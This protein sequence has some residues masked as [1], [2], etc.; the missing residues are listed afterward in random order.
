[1]VFNAGLSRGAAGRASETCGIVHASAS[2][3]SGRVAHGNYGRKQMDALANGRLFLALLCCNRDEVCTFAMP[4]LQ[5][6]FTK[7]NV[8]SSMIL[9]STLQKQTK[10]QWDMKKAAL[11][12]RRQQQA[13]L[14]RNWN[15]QRNLSRRH[16]GQPRI[17]NQGD[18][19]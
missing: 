19:T 7:P 18:L 11:R 6:I 15:Q 2:S 3:V 10:P 9:G 14:V 12:M 1:M 17:S 13:K 16:P 5:E 8:V 4:Q